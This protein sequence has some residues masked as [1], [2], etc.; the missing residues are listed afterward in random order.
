M[1]YCARELGFITRA[2]TWMS[3]NCAGYRAMNVTAGQAVFGWLRQS[4]HP[5]AA[6]TE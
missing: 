3:P 6:A 4:H 5:A 2:A 1:T